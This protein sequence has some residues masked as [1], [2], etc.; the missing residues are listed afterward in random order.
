MR[1]TS[2]EVADKDYKEKKDKFIYENYK[3]FKELIFSINHK[4][5]EGEIAIEHVT[6]SKT[7]KLPKGSAKIAIKTLETSYNTKDTEDM[8]EMQE[9]Y[10]SAKMGR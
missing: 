6:N 5:K 1:K 3:S 2:R 10:E 8:R 7:T 9:K 4:T